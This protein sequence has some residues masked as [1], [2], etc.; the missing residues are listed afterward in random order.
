MFS[1]SYGSREKVGEFQKLTEKGSHTAS[2]RKNHLPH[3]CENADSIQL[4][5]SSTVST[6]LAQEQLDQQSSNE[7][8]ETDMTVYRDLAYDRDAITHWWGKDG[9]LRGCCLKTG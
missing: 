6:V 2:L 7:S 5:H 9:W 3:E 1:I 4:S 8:P